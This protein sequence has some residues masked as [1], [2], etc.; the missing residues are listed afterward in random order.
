MPRSVWLSCFSALLLS[1]FLTACHVPLTPPPTVT[2]TVTLT[3]IPKGYTATAH[4][5]AISAQGQ[6][7]TAQAQIAAGRTAIAQN[8]TL[9]PSATVIPIN[10]QP[11]GVP[12]APPPTFMLGGT[13][14][15]HHLI[16]SFTADQ[17]TVNPGDSVMLRWQT[18][19]QTVTLCTTWRTGQMGECFP[20][21]P[22][23]NKQ[24][25]TRPEDR[26][27]VQYILFAQTGDQSENASV[28]IT[29]TCPV[30]WF[31]TPAPQGCPQDNA[32]M[33]DGA[34]QHFQHGMMIWVGSLDAIFIL[35]EDDVFSPKW[36]RAQDPWVDGMAE[37]TADP[38]KP[39]ALYE[40]V[41]GFGKVWR[42]YYGD[43]RGRLG[44]AKEEEFGFQT[45]FQCDSAP[46]Y[47][48]CYLQGPEGVIVL[49]PERSKWHLWA[50]Q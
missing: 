17:G 38:D 30:T 2:P 14:D 20:V 48:T 49:E 23:G 1:C 39:D 33:G 16:A 5:A 43:V 3:L 21:L 32:I 6:T 40:P 45:A 42:E 19:G 8:I 4:S 27:F 24:F 34:A 28:T 13:M 41:R 11:A 35:Y 25:T 46:K 47:N 31:F 10:T 22:N 36:D 37:P 15:A 9:T 12:P 29:L 26:E 50:G 7:A 18:T 44:W